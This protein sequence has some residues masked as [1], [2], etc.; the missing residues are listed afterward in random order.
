MRRTT[1]W[2]GA[3]AGLL[4]GMTAL[5]ARALGI[6]EIVFTESGSSDIVAGPG[7]TITAEIRITAGA[8]GISSYGVSIAFDSDLDFVSA[9][10]LLPSAYTFNLSA[11]IDGSEESDP[12]TLGRVLTFEAGT[13]GPGAVSETFLAGTITFLVVA[14]LTDGPDLAAGLF[15]AGI[16]GIFDS[17]G[18]VVEAAFG[19]ASV[20]PEPGTVALL[21]AG[22]AALARR[23]RSQR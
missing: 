21:G 6:V 9:T 20:T 15:N 4:L 5:E 7:D 10:E 17:N 13:F 2:V 8:E 19:S 16:D 14:P 3:L 12:S 18:G 22:L 1:K 23:R 11:G